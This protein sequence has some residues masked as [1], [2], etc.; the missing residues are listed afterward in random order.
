MH[1]RTAA[2]VPFEALSD[3]V[4]SRSGQYRDAAAEEDDKETD[5]GCRGGR[6]VAP[7]RVGGGRGG[8]KCRLKRFS[9]HSLR[10]GSSPRKG[11]VIRRVEDLHLVGVR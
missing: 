5:S 8:M 11:S 7:G 3:P 9:Q 1:M 6:K 10:T 2:R 4:R